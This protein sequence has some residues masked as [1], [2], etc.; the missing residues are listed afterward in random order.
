MRTVVVGAGP[1]GLFCGLVLARNG[2]QVTVVDRDPPPPSAGAWE[3]RGVMQFNLPHFFRNIV[4]QTLLENLPEAW[5]ALIGAGC[6]PAVPEGLPEAMTGLQARRSTFERAF[7][8]LAASDPALKLQTGHVDT[9]TT[10]RDQ[11]AGVLVEGAEMEADVVIVA[12]GRTARLGHEQRAP[13]EGGSC[14]FSYAARMYRARDS[15]DPPASALPMGAMHRGYL[16]IVFPQDDKT[17]SALFVRPSA[18]NLGELRK[19]ECFEAAARLVP[20]LA[21]WTD[22]ERFKPITAVMAGSGLSNTY[23]GQLDDAGRAG[24]AGLFY[25]GD[26]VCTTNPAAGRGVSLG[27]R[28]GAE[29]VRLLSTADHDYRAIAEQF[30]RWCSE[31]IRPWYEDHVYWDATLLARLNGQDIDLD[32]PLASDV[33]CAAAGQDPSMMPVVGP[34]M[35]ML[36][37]PERVEGCRRKGPCRAPRRVATN[38]G[39]RA[40][41]GGTCGKAGRTDSQQVSSLLTTGTGPPWRRLGRQFTSQLDDVAPEAT[42]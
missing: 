4:R 22:Q 15:V 6:V 40:Y 42:A 33:I 26:T 30:D 7:W 24:V 32:A 41:R 10:R 12:A 11:V 27:L 21:P 3:R 2:H 1:V 36:L 38:L 8:S 5:G 35:G 23:R 28:Q 18:D 20:N 34:F 13:G 39:C 17:L 25:V 9:L 37:P 31:H 29:L 16:T 19:D 14:G